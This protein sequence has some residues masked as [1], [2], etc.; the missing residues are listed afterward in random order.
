MRFGIGLISILLAAAI[1]FYVSFGYG[2]HGG[3]EGEVLHQG[4]DLREQAA[5]LAGKDENNM[6]AQD[7]IVLDDVMSG[8][9]LRGEKVVSL[10]P[11]GPMITAYGLQPGD[12]IIQA[13]QMDLRG[14]DAGLARS[15][16]VESYSK[17]QPLV[18]MRNGQEMTLN[19]VNSALTEHHLDMFQ[20]TNSGVVPLPQ[21]QSIPTH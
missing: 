8:S 9:E 12:Q 20:H 10:V 17:N 2:K 5:Q 19:P 1:I 6:T 21:G 3:Y 18:V 15:L 11:G 7:S 13:E 4:R 14:S 16:I